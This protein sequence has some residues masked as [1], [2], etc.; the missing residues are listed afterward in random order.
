MMGFSAPCTLVKQPS[1]WLLFSAARAL[2]W[3]LFNLL[4]AET[5]HSLS[6]EL[7]PA[8]QF[9]ACIVANVMGFGKEKSLQESLSVVLIHSFWLGYPVRG[10]PSPAQQR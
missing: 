4:S 9:P 10:S 6:A 5:P 3:L 2:C 8:S 1:L 7:S